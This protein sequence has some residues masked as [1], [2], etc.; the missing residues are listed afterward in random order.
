MCSRQGFGA[1][2]Y[3]VFEFYVAKRIW[4]Y[5]SRREKDVLPQRAHRSQKHGESALSFSSGRGRLVPVS[6]E[7]WRSA[8]A[9]GFSGVSGFQPLGFSWGRLPGAAPIDRLCPR[10][11]SDA[12]LALKEGLL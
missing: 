1:A 6:K 7:A 8:G 11:V 2:V 3:V 10:L 12:P 5:P 9:L 4:L